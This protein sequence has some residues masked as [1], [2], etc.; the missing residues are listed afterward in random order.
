MQNII[1]QSNVAWRR[2]INTTN[3]TNDN[4]AAQ[5]NASVL[6]GLTNQAQNNLWQEYRDVAHQLYASYENDRQ[7]TH[8]IIVTG[9][10]NQF[11]S[12]QFQNMLDYRASVAQG[13]AINGWV[14]NLLGPS[15]SKGVEIGLESIFGD[16]DK[17][18]TELLTVDTFDPYYPVA[19]DTSGDWNIGTPDTDWYSL[20]PE[21]E[22]EY[23]G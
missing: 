1:D 21:E 18:L 3:T 5:K 7:R 10:K 17:E 6:L 23:F 4:L 14:T 20:V 16:N 13:A 8:D 22:G 2:Q 11:S 9:I 19:E 12:E 15:L